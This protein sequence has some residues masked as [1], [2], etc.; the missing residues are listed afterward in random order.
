MEE[1]SILDFIKSIL[2]PWDKHPIQIPPLKDDLVVKGSIPTNLSNLAEIPSNTETI[3][4]ETTRAE[5]EI[6]TYEKVILRSLAPWSVI[7]AFAFAFLAQWFFAPPS[8]API[9]GILSLITSFSL[10]ILSYRLHQSQIP[11]L[12][13]SIFIN[14]PLTVNGKS[15]IIGSIFAILTFFASS[16]NKF[17]ILNLTLLFLSLVFLWHA[18]WIRRGNTK[19]KISKAINWLAQPS[20]KINL[21]RWSLL[22]IAITTII[23]F[24]R[25]FHLNS[26]PSEMVS[27]HAE[28]YLDV[29]DILSGQTHIFF[30]RNGGREALQFYFIAGLQKCFGLGTNFLTLKISTSIIGLLA[31]PFIY[32]LGKEIGNQRIGLIALAFAGIA[33][34]S[35]VVSRAG[36]RLPFYFLFTAALLYY[37]FRGIRTSN[38]ND[39]ILAGLW[40]GLSFYGYS[41][42]RFLPFI[43]IIAIMLFLLHPQS[44][45]KRKQ[46]IW[47]TLLLSLMAL[48]IFLPLLRYITQ[49]PQGYSQR[50]ISRLAGASPL[51]KSPWIIFLDNF[52]HAVTMFSWS[53][54]VVW[55]ASIPDYPALGIISG[56]LFYTGL[57]FVLIRYFL[58][59]NWLDLFLLVSIPLLMMPSILSLAFPSEN[60]NLYRTGGALIPVFLLIGFALDLLMSSLESYYEHVRG[61]RIAW[62]TFIILFVFSAIINYN[63]VFD[64]YNKQ[65]QL[66]AWNTSEVGEV[67][68][69]F[70]N[71][72]GS[73]DT[74]WVMGF[75]HWVDTRLVSLNAGFPGHEFALFPEQLESTTDI[76]QPKLFILNQA[77]NEALEILQRIYPNGW[78]KTYNSKVPTK[79]FL[80]FTVFPEP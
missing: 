2:N 79:D 21:S 60:P 22:L 76:L 12:P 39:F 35:N 5:T 32:L 30:P 20:W 55:V 78:L 7:S 24:F 70:A 40:L 43:V 6:H 57:C 51:T 34:W 80:I 44:S 48:I 16:G 27:D 61:S 18:F 58:K 77:D 33:Y 29:W 15:F 69:D 54:G 17:T 4:K 25:F 14:D 66:S 3:Q 49:D 62:V 28:K 13:K 50:M 38:R 10:A 19:G 71:S 67:I 64:T 47:F 68:H 42:D 73:A 45:G 63:L 23:L 37:L 65:Y 8:R 11:S 59:R 56:G 53:D 9:M 36:M 72:I 52:W 75:P 26:I 46:T 31:L 1:P 74:A 41:A